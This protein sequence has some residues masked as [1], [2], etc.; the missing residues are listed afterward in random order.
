MNNNRADQ[1]ALEAGCKGTF[2][3]SSFITIG[4]KGC[5]RLWVVCL[6]RA[7]P[8]LDGSAKLLLPG[9]SWCTEINVDFAALVWPHMWQMLAIAPREMQS[10]PCCLLWMITCRSEVGPAAKRPY[11][12]KRSISYTP[13]P[14]VITCALELQHESANRSALVSQEA[15]AVCEEEH[16]PPALWRQADRRRVAE[17]G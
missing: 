2:S 12:R 4:D 14:A 16:G 3:P 13:V 17:A 5:A 6:A 10:W 7:I 11:M 8:V 9:S 1:R 15:R